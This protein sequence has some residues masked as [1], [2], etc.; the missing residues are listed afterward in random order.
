MI[1]FIFLIL[2]YIVPGWLIYNIWFNELFDDSLERW[3]FI[4]SLG[5]ILSLLNMVSLTGL[6]AFPYILSIMGINIAFNL[7]TLIALLSFEILILSYINYRNDELKHFFSIKNKLYNIH[8][9]DKYILVLAGLVISVFPHIYYVITNSLP[10]TSIVWTYH[11]LTKSII[12]NGGVSDTSYAYG[13]FFESS[14]TYISYQLLSSHIFKILNLSDVNFLRFMSIFNPLFSYFLIY[15]TYKNML[16]HPYDVAATTITMLMRLFI[17]KLATHKSESLSIVTLFI[18]YW[19][20]IKGHRSNNRKLMILGGLCIAVNISTNAAIALAG[21]CLLGA[22]SLSEA[23]FSRSLVP[24]FK[25][26]KIGIVALICV[27]LIFTLASGKVPLVESFADPDSYSVEEDPSWEFIRILYPDSP[28]TPSFSNYM[29]RYFQSEMLNQMNNLVYLFLASI[30]TFLFIKRSREKLLSVLLFELALLAVGLFFY[31][32]YDTYVPEK[33]GFNRV[34][35]YSY[36][37]ISIL[38]V[39]L[40]ETLPDLT[41]Q[42]E[43]RVKFSYKQLVIVAFIL[44]LFNYNS[45]FIRSN[46]IVS[47]TQEGY[48]SMLWLKDNSSP[49]SVLLT[50]EWTNGAIS[51]MSERR[52]LDDGDAPYLR[53]DAVDNVGYILQ[54]TRAFYENPSLDSQLLHEYNVTHV[55]LSIGRAFRAKELV[56]GNP[57]TFEEAGFFPVYIGE[58]IIIYKIR[59]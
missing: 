6:Y 55:I 5:F 47:V 29:P 31:V 28:E 56:E 44:L 37:A 1:R 9:D 50:N 14:N 23:I 20:S 34:F 36:M 26:M 15:F 51:G 58:N 49:D 57:E 42:I 41:L 30:S 39:T 43:K 22:I 8:L 3:G 18:A 12:N 53:M 45:G 4:F 59:D 19:I 33:S 16:K 38:A 40:I 17:F 2:T 54:E 32:F 21:V 35:P 10:A 11:S 46:H 7:T 24:L 52:V 27:L 13:M 25:T 48:E